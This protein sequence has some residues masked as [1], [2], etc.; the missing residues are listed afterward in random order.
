MRRLLI[1]LLLTS[2][3]FQSAMA[4]APSA[5]SFVSTPPALT[6]P[7]KGGL[8]VAKRFDGPSGLTGWL[9]KDSSGIF[10]TFWTTSD[11][12]LMMAGALINEQGEN[13]TQKFQDQYEP[14]ADLAA[15]WPQL[16]NTAQIVTGPQSNP[17]GV[18]YVFIDPN[19]PFCHS[20]WLALRHYEA[21][22]LQVHWVIV[23]FLHEDSAGK[24]AALLSAPDQAEALV[25]SQSNFQAGGIKP[26]ATI[27]DALKASLRD[28][29]N[30]MHAFGFKG[31]P[32]ILYK[33]AKGTIHTHDGMP[34]LAELPAI[35]G[36]PEQNV[37]D[38]LLQRFK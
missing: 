16:Q 12:A 19:C 22:G 27:P 35:T 32:G 29:L 6:V 14:K 18:V 37:D 17:K 33:D 30:L 36:L 21:A 4:A 38:P 20:L 2:M 31:V 8:T 7:I 34:K 10:Y 11:G 13:L 28:N 15:L 26:L 3:L 9:M 25:N 24:A 1:S 23:G 5:S